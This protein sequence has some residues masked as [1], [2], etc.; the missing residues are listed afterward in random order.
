VNTKLLAA[1]AAG[2]ID[3]LNDDPRY[4]MPVNQVL[5]DTYTMEATDKTN[6][7]T[8]PTGRG[9]HKDV[10]N[11]S[12]SRDPWG[13]DVPRLFPPLRVGQGK[14]DKLGGVS[15][16]VLPMASPTGTHGFDF[17]GD[18]AKKN[19]E[20]CKNECTQTGGEDPCG[21]EDKKF[22]DLGHYM[23]NLLGTYVKSDGKKLEHKPCLGTN[24][25]PDLSPPPE[26]RDPMTLP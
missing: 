14:L 10:D 5:I 17:P 18:M 1:R 9:V 25:C 4:G 7:F 2:L 3:Y 13:S 24:D 6:R 16:V 26:P 12:D 11:L 20:K 15:G 19:M 21:C 22:F 8:D 23:I